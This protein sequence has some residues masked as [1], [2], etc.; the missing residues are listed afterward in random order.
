MARKGMKRASSMAQRSGNVAVKCRKI[1][2]CIRGADDV[3][4]PVRTMLCDTLQ[5]TFGTYKEERHAFQNEAS[6]LVGSILNSQQSKLQAAIKES[7]AK[8]AAVGAEH[9]S[10][11]AANDAAVGASEAA[12]KALADSKTAITDS[13]TALKDAK[14]KLHDLEAETKS[15]EVEAAAAASKKE[16][17]EVLVNDFLPG[18]KAGT[19]AGTR[20]G[21]RVSKDVASSV[22]ED[23]LKCVSRTFVKPVSTWGT[24]DKIVAERLDGFISKSLA[25]VTAEIA[26]LASAKEAR[27]ANV[28]SAKAA[29]TTAEETAKAKEEAS[30]AA[31]AAAKEAEASAAGTRKAL[32]QHQGHVSK[33]DA[34]CK[35]AENAL[36]AFQNGPLAA[37]TEVEARKAPE[38]EP[39]APAEAAPAAP[40]PVAAAM[41][42]APAQPAARPSILSSP[43]VLMQQARRMLSSPNLEQSSQ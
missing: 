3:P 26:S 31:A 2:A 20:A 10:A 1:A 30:V 40:A 11:S 21:N 13:K 27:A 37:Y 12:A 33:A 17:L 36:A 34:E 18:I 4:K 7:Q 41:A 29:I 39:E 19:N 6:G 28:E 8:R 38:P 24:F 43:Q 22:D 9:D 35:E 14:A 32:N 23:F 42:P 16:T 25:E 15:A 5:R